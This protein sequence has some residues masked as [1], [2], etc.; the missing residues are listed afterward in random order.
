MARR[1]VLLQV[2][3]DGANFCGFAPQPGQRTVYGTLLDAVR[4][5]DASVEGLR[6][7]SRTDAGVHAR[8]QAVAFDTALGVPARGWVLGV[9]ARL[10]TDVA[11]RA[12]RE[13]EEGF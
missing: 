10:P 8:G 9:N 5:M 4:G 1:G 13:V 12:A 3:Y 2:A 6:G 7:A 11:V